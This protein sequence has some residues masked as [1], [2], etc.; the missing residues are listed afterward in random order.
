[1]KRLLSAIL[2]FA[3]ITSLFV[4][5]AAKKGSK[6]HTI[7]FKDDFKSEKVF[8]TFFNTKSDKKKTVKMKKYSEDKKSITFSREGDTSKYNM[9][10]ITYGNKKKTFKFAF[11]KCVSG[12]HKTK[13]NFLPYTQGKKTNYFAKYDDI[14]LK[15]KGYNKKIHIWKPDDYNSDSTEKYNTVYVL[16]AHIL[17]SI[18]IEEKNIGACPVAAEQINAMNNA[19]GKKSILVAIENIFA[20]DNETVPKIGISS[21]EKHF[22]KQ[23]YNSLNGSQLADFTAEKLAPYIRNH[24]NVYK[25]ARHTAIAG[26]SLSGL[27]AFYIGTEHPE[28]FGTIGALSPSFW[29]FDNKTWNKY[30]SKKKF[31]AKSPFI[32]FFTGPAKDDIGPPVTDM[33]KRLKKYGYP[34]NKLAIHYNKDA[35]HSAEWW[36]AVFSEFLSAM[37]YQKNEPLQN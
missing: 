8:L 6:Y 16:D 26:V 1:M 29:E 17:T 10:Y 18:G 37:I 9:A 3:V 5:C 35:Y 36:R 33:Y 24:Y 22:G 20:R 13:T 2:I 21:D 7:Y 14:T 19:T 15:Y 30:I 31:G 28:I 25:D 11:N 4:S 23:E 34:K 12:W 32:Y 27:E